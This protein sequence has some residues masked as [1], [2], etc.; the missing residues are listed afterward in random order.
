[1]YGR[2]R[3]R[4]AT[5][6]PLFAAAAVASL[7]GTAPARAADAAPGQ[8]V[9][10]V[11]RVEQTLIAGRRFDG[12]Y[13][14]TLTLS[15][16]STRRLVFTP[17]I[18]DRMLLVRFGDTSGGRPAGPNDNTFMG[19]NGTV[20]DGQLLVRLEAPDYPAWKSMDPLRLILRFDR[21]PNPATMRF[22][23]WVYELPKPGAMFS[24]FSDRYQRVVRLADGRERTIDVV[25][26]ARGGS[27]LLRLTDNGQTSWLAPGETIIRD[28]LMIQTG[29]LVVD[30]ARLRQPPGPGGR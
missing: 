1:M 25:A 6:L 21:W 7:A 17:V 11:D 14:T 27:P 24:V 8:F 10:S 18:R 3:R 15:D 20:N 23:L 13:A 22:R 29:R 30:A 4:I 26:T 2:A 12:P 16:G 19:P 5:I 28:G 9:I